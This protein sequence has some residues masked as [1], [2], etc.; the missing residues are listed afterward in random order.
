[1]CGCAVRVRC[2]RLRRRR[3]YSRPALAP[4]DPG[5]ERESADDPV[6]APTQPR[7]VTVR[8]SASQ[9]ARVPPGSS[10]A[11]TAQRSGRRNASVLEAM[12]TGSTERSP[13]LTGR[14][15]NDRPLLHSARWAVGSRRRRRAALQEQQSRAC[16]GG[17]R[18]ALDVARA[19]V[20]RV[21]I[22][23]AAVAGLD[24]ANLGVAGVD[25]P[26]AAVARLDVASLAYAVVDIPAAAV[27]RLDV[28]DAAVALLDV[29]PPAV[30]GIHGSNTRGAGVHIG[31]GRNRDAAQERR[32]DDSGQGDDELEATH[33]TPI[34]R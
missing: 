12:P 3:W 6:S 1:M 13:R 2:S 31:S 22:P 17:C 9:R 11:Q 21:D 26:A 32:K 10:A 23:A 16:G 28:S 27:R 33:A 19:R 24:V 18:T 14:L 4:A 5:S 25:V 7:H 29:V 34:L 8:I 20:A 30:A 15:S